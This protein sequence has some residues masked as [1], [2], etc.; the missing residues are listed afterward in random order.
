MIDLRRQGATTETLKL[1]WGLLGRD[2]RE[3]SGGQF[4]G[5]YR[6]LDAGLNRLAVEV[7]QPRPDPGQLQ[8]AKAKAG[9]G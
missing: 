8:E 7:Q 4:I 5:V 1:I 3:T 2:V 6:A 9:L